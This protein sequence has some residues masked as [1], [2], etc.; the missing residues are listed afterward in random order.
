MP[1]RDRRQI[2][3]KFAVAS[4]SAGCSNITIGKPLESIFVS[5]INNRHRRYA[6][7]SRILGFYRLPSPLITGLDDI[8]FA[9]Q[10]SP[11]IGILRLKPMSEFLYR[12]L[13]PS[14]LHNSHTCE[15][16]S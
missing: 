13:A 10:V 15:N 11:Y 5:D 9:Q 12:T 6:I 8:L 4:D 3:V 2:K 1:I 16:D 7:G 14:P